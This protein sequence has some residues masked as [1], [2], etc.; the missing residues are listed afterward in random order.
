MIVKDLKACWIIDSRANPTI[1]VLIKTEKAIG[2]GYAPSGASKGD[3][4]A[5][6]IRD[7]EKSFHGKGVEKALKNVEIIR[8]AI[9]GKE[10]SSEEEIDE[11][12]I[13]LDGTKNKSKIGGNVTTACSMAAL[14]VMAK[15][16]DME[17]FEYLS[18][19]LKLKCS[20]PFCMFNIINGGKHA[21]NKLAIQEFLIVPMFDDIRLSV[22]T[23]CEIY[24]QLRESLIKK[25]GK[26]SVNVGDEG[27]FSPGFKTCVDTLDF[28]LKVIEELG[29]EKDVKIS[30]D[31]A[32]S[33]FYDEKK[34]KYLIDSKSLEPEELLDYYVNLVKNYELLSLEDPFVENHVYLFK[35]L[36]KITNVLGDDLTVSNVDFAKKYEEMINGLILKPNQVGTIKET[37]ETWK[38]ARV[39]LP[40]IVTSHRSGETESSFISD[41]AVGIS[42][43]YVKFGAPARG[44]RTA[45]YNRLME[46]Q[47]MIRG[48]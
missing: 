2:I 30:I 27:G 4:E 24:V 10:F 19:K 23:A 37:L 42:S 33:S 11:L 17:I 41:F 36:K 40:F 13:K 12:L 43:P 20:M 15:E 16:N 9:I 6:E 34:D 5:V 21:G 29:Y 22:K 3:K 38:Y 32:S 7:N 44:E 35:E 28:M 14:D 18:Y 8:K 48:W 26:Q 45:K 25:F 46:I 39:K 1:K 47:D 31:A